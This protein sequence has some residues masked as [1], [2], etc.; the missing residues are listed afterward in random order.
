MIVNE[1]LVL[2]PVGRA[3]GRAT[4]W[5]NGKIA[6]CWTGRFGVILDHAIVLR[7]MNGGYWMVDTGY[8]I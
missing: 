6:R 8:R 2:G 3:N 1:S 5:A 7:M 4:G